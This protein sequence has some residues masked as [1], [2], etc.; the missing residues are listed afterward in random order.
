M[1]ESLLELLRCINCGG[2]LAFDNQGT[3]CDQLKEGWLRCAG[4]SARYPVRNGMPFIHREDG[5]WLSCVREAEGWV[6]QHKD[7]GI[8]DQTNV[9]IDFRLPYFSEEPWVKVAKMFDIALELLNPRAGQVIL[10]LGAGR[11]W[12]AKHFSLRGCRS[13][14]IDVVAD[15][16][17]GL[18]RS[19]AL[20]KEAGTYYEAVI[21]DHERMPFKLAAFDIVFSCGSIHHTSDVRVLVSEI[22]R[23]LKRG[24]KLLAINE[25]CIGV[26]EDEKEVLRRD[27]AEEIA[28][29]IA[30]RRPNLL[31]YR[32]ALEA[33]DF[34][35]IN[36]FPYNSYGVPD[37][38]IRSWPRQLNVSVLPRW[39]FVV[40][41]KRGL[42][43]PLHAVA[44]LCKTLRIGK[45]R[46]LSREEAL[47]SIMLQRG[48]DVV[49]VAERT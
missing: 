3:T 27:C 38:V 22:A 42:R 33:A 23:V 48:S 36:L 39:F 4:C 20:M 21:G 13:V 7:K 31:Q 19:Q 30:E 6:N 40:A 34:A 12:A 26:H 37:N 43:Q 29:S 28:Y 44:R 18:G 11:G 41:R 47:E 10:D 35:K 15:D 9:D 49:I 25:P 46:L 45:R 1:R 2:N 17:I 8:Y 32:E 24:G 14:A 16:Q 5:R